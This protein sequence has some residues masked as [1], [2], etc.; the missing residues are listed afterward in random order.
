VIRFTIGIEFSCNGTRIS[1]AISTVVVA[2]IRCIVVS[3]EPD[4]STVP[5]LSPCSPYPMP[6]WGG[7]LDGSI[8]S[9]AGGC[10]AEKETKRKSGFSLSWLRMMRVASCA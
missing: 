9:T 7:A 1:C 4:H 5:L 2:F 6:V 10:T 3:G 8:L